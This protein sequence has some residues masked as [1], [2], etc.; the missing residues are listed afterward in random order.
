MKFKL[1]LWLFAFLLSSTGMAGDKTL[2]RIGALAFGTVN[3]EL[4]ALNKENLLAN[5]GFELQII[6][7][8]NPQAGKI[9]LQ[10]KAVDLIVSD[11]IWVSR[12]R[13]G[14]SDY[15]F[16]PYSNTSGALVVPADSPI[17]TL[18]EL[19]GKKLGIA[20]GELDKN[21]LLLQALGQ[22]Q[23][24]ELDDAVTKVY[25]APP[26]LNQQ[27]LQQRIDAV[28]NYWHFAARLEAKGFRQILDGAEILR[29]LGIEEQVPSLGYV[30]RQSWANRH[31][32][33]IAEFLQLTAEAKDRLCRSDTTWAKIIPLTKAKDSATQDMLRQRYCEGRVQK[34]GKANQLAAE[35]IYQLLRRLS[36]NK[37][38]G[39]SEQLQAGTFWQRD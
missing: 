12:M 27:L 7:M 3:W 24:I 25:G 16:Y 28:I 19:Q 23:N 29:Q 37:L 22:R 26:L 36:G 35:K 15:T 34:W 9:A 31:Q 39:S 5:A 32:Q 20:G 11:W 10:S 30:F 21:W 4:A 13:A 33:A 18:T 38:T 6:P 2:I 17:Q 14:G 8:A 1:T